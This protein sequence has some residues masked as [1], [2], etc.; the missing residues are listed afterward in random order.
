MKIVNIQT[1]NVTLAA[2]IIGLAS[3]FSAAL[4]IL[5]D[6]L[7]A[8]KFGAGDEL[9][10]YYAAFRIPDFV[11][12]VF[13]MGAIS[14][15]VIPIFSEYLTRDK[16]E[17]WKFLSNLFNLILFILIIVCAVLIVFTPQLVNLIT[18]GFSEEKRELVSLLTRIMFLSPIILGTSNIIASSI[19][20][21]T[22]TAS[23]QK[24]WVSNTIRTAAPASRSSSTRTARSAT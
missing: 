19:S 3:V 21:E 18:P 20:R 12:M 15:A 23:K 14:A 22:G 17:A 10:V 13:I 24:W 11:S 6:R 5:R 2:V 1:K 16:E 7:L 8:G 9:D 4:G